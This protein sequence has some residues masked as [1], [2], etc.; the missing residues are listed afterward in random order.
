L[1]SGGGIKETFSYP[2]LFELY[3]SFGNLNR[4]NGNYKLTVQRGVL[5]ESF[6]TND[7]HRK[8]NLLDNA[9]EVKMV[10]PNFEVNH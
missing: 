6:C 7:K 5:G 9:S 8:V 3:C 1:L 10:E 4:I 2:D